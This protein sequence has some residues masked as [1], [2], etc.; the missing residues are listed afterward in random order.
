MSVHIYIYTP[1]HIR[2]CIYNDTTTTTTTTTTTPPGRPSGGGSRRRGPSTWRPRRLIIS[3]IIIIVM[4]IIV[5]IS[6]IIIIIIIIIIMFIMC[7]YIYICKEAQQSHSL[8]VAI[9]P[10]GGIGGAAH[11]RSV[12][13]PRTSPAVYVH[14]RLEPVFLS[15]SLFRSG[16]TAIYK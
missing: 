4:I 5:I 11:N 8:T 10:G 14:R 15:W 12:S 13:I 7:I 1:L 2:I 9:P 16:S 6:I 3:S